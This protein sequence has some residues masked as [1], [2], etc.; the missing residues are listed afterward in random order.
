M[1]MLENLL[2]LAMLEALGPY[3]K[4]LAGATTNKLSGLYVFDDIA[5]CILLDISLKNNYRK[6]VVALSH[7]LGHHFAGVRSNFLTVNNHNEHILL[8]KDESQAMRWATDYVI[9]DAKL[10]YA[11]NELKLR[12]CWELAEY[13]KVTQPFMWR[14]LGF[15]RNC[16]RA[17][18]I[19]VKS[20]DIFTIQMSPCFVSHL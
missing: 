13:F 11:V 19:K 16:F 6:H 10:I 17:T 9:P 12:S 2:E 20:R 3:Y 18:G 4:N 15:L 7:E 8:I 5:P 1:S 14:K